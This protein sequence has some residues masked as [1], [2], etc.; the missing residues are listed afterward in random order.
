MR[1]VGH[2]GLSRSRIT[3]ACEHRPGSHGER[4]ER[5][6]RSELVHL[7]SAVA[8]DPPYSRD[9]ATQSIEF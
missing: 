7:R 5:V 1:K 2:G 3:V 6:D 4:H 8:S 9:G